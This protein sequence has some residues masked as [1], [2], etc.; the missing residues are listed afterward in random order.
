MELSE[1]EFF[2]RFFDIN[3]SHAQHS[4]IISQKRVG[5]IGDVAEREREN[6]WKI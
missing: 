1:W 3:N 2:I 5:L 4:F 6:I